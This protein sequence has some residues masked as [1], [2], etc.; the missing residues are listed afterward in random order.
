MLNGT[1]ELLTEEGVVHSRGAQRAFWPP[2]CDVRQMHKKIRVSVSM[3][4]RPTDIQSTSMP[5]DIHLV[6]VGHCCAWQI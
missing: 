4:R 2:Y 5:I 6:L 3:G 1:V